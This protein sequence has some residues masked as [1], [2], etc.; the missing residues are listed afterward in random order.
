MAMLSRIENGWFKERP[1]LWPGQAMSLEVDTVLYAGK[2]EFQDVLVF[3]SAAY[4]NV[5]VLDGVIQVT[6]RDEF[7]Y[8]EMITHL[9]MFSHPNPQRIL[10]V[11]GGD[12]GVVRE[13]LKHDSVQEVYLCEID[14]TV[15]DVAKQFLP[16]MA[17]SYKDPRVSIKIM[18]GAQFMSE[19]QDFFDVIITDSSDPVGPADVLFKPP[20]FEKMNSALRQG[21]IICSQGECI[22]L[23]LD[24]IR[25]LLESCRLIFPSVSYA[26]T[27]IPTYPSGQIGFVLCGKSADTSFSNPHRV[28]EP[29]SAIQKKLRYYNHDIHKAAFVLPEF[30]RRAIAGEKEE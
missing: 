18:D 1:T 23:H 30:A 9:A 7:A 29:G 17:S 20:Y 11:G 14:E 28:C 8:Q 25:P 13:V 19:N 21:G 15:I 16:S 6:E 4:G 26:Y 12:G 5:L 2:S 24:L 3:K 22:W 10:V 27:T